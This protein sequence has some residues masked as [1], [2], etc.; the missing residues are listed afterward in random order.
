MERRG[1]IEKLT[2]YL[3]GLWAG[4]LVLGS[5]EARAARAVTVSPQVRPG[6]RVGAAGRS[7][8]KTRPKPPDWASPTGRSL[9]ITN[10][11]VSEC[12]AQCAAMCDAQCAGA[13]CTKMCGGECTSMCAGQC[14]IMCGSGAIQ[15]CL[16]AMCSSMC[17]IE[18]TVCVR[19]AC[20]DM[21]A[22]EN[23]GCFA[24][25]CKSGTVNEVRYAMTA[26]RSF[27]FRFNLAHISPKYVKFRPQLI[28]E[29]Y[30]K[31]TA[32][33]SRSKSFP[34]LDKIRGTIVR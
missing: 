30:D 20:N 14:D 21:C 10:A 18:H 4:T 2:L 23:V 34:E 5:R 6:V 32:G 26:L 27:E 13:M 9:T 7:D 3:S 8:T 24:M 15:L 12:D 28:E 1:F 16:V 33:S 22:V 31:F 17:A 19:M 29:F 11:C 25:S